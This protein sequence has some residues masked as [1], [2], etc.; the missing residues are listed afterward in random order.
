LYDNLEWLEESLAFVPKKEDQI[1]PGVVSEMVID[2]PLTNTVFTFAGD[3]YATHFGIEQQVST[4]EYQAIAL[5]VH[6]VA[7]SFKEAAPNELNAVGESLGGSAPVEISFTAYANEP[8]AT[9]YIWKIVK[10]DPVTQDSVTLVRYTDKAITYRFED[11]GNFTAQLEVVDAQSVCF[12]NSQVFDVFIGDSDLQLPNAFSP[13]STPGVNDE[14]R[15]AYKSLVSFKASIYNRW[16][17]LLYH[18]EDPSQ[19]WD[20]RVAGKYVPTGVYFIVVEAK[21]ADGKVYRRSSDINV[22][23]RK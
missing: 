23:R 10:K 6:A 3:D 15:V 2:A 19:G 7:E 12:N 22:L 1:E 5:E 18:W 14:Y 11:T 13:G 20:G 16:G 8:V 21:G 9:M 17:N 4:A